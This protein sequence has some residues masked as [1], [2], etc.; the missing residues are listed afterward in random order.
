[1]FADDTSMVDD[2]AVKPKRVVSDFGRVH[3]KRK[4]NINMPKS[5]VMR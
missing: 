5:K 3:Q 2:S 1:M 4:L